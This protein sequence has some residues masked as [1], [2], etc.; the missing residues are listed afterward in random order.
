MASVPLARAVFDLSFWI[1]A[2]L[3]SAAGVAC[4]VLFGPETVEESLHTDVALI[5]FLVPK[6]GA[7]FL[8]AAF[9]QILIPRDK[10]AAWIGE[11]SGVKGMVI[12]GAAGVVTPGGPMT[13]FPVVSALHAAGTGRAA[14]VSY[15][16]AWSTLGL[17]R[18]LT[19]EIPLMGMEFAVLRFVA[20]LP[21]PIVAGLVARMIPIRIDPP[22]RT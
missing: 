5:V 9:V 8:I 10:V 22:G 1:I 11:E 16:T 19:W 2:G 21:L 15:L 4:W 17:Q 14:L 6:L 12:A 7:A 13:S 20:S 18:I 3:A